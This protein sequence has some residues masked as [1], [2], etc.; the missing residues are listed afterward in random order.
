MERASRHRSRSPHPQ[1]WEC[2][3]GSV[4]ICREEFSRLVE[5]SFVLGSRIYGH[6]AMRAEKNHN[7]F[8][9]ISQEV[10]NVIRFCVKHSSLPCDAL[11]MDSYHSGEL[12]HASELLGGF[13][14]VDKAILKYEAE[15]DAHRLR[16]ETDMSVRATTPHSRG[17]GQYEWRCIYHSGD[18]NI[19]FKL[20]EY[21]KEGFEY[22]RT[23]R[24]AFGSECIT[25]TRR[26]LKGAAPASS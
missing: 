14:S 21:A 13:A 20:E 2:A 6:R 4:W 23:T 5:D 26:S 8:K 22:A 24:L 25:S 10:L 15:K 12:R 17:A 18:E 7:I 16:R 19:R 3:N 11:A 1:R 9:E